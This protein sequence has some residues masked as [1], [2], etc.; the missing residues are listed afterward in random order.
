MDGVLAAT[1]WTAVGTAGVTGLT[2]IIVS[3]LGVLSTRIT[4]R[5]SA[6]QIDA[7]ATRADAARGEV[8]RSHR[9]SVYHGLLNAERNCMPVIVDAQATNEK[10]VKAMLSLAEHINGAILFGTEEVGRHALTLAAMINQVRLGLHRSGG[11]EDEATEVFVDRW[12][13]AR[14]DLI[15]AMRLDIAPDSAPISAWPQWP[16]A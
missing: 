14:H 8:R 13:Q 16:A 12:I 15:D 5:V 7:E 10:R 11:I 3:A 4:A 6:R 2:A 1:N 9:Q